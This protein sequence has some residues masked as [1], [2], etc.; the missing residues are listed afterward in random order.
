[1]NIRK[2]GRMQGSKVAEQYGEKGKSRHLKSCL[3]YMHIVYAR[4]RT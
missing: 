4:V 2:C 3:E 1:M